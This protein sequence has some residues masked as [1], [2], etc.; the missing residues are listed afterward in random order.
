MADETDK[1]ER[2]LIRD[3]KTGIYNNYEG[4][5]TA[6]RARNAVD[7]LDNAYGAYRYEVVPHSKATEGSFENPKKNLA[8]K[9]GVAATLTGA[10]AAAKAGEYGEAVN[11]A[12]DLFVPPFAESRA[13]QEGHDEELAQRRTKPPTIDKARGGK[14]SISSRG[15]GIAKRGKTKGRYL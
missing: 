8:G 6:S 15:D 5:S 14:V 2:Y 7:K 4:Y 11:K 9:L 13:T 10:A 12:T 1:P 3:R